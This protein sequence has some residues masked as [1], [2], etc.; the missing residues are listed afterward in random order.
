MERE[1]P[2]TGQTSANIR[3]EVARTGLPATQVAQ[4]V[5]LTY[6]QWQRRINNKVPWRMD[7]VGAIARFLRVRLDVLTGD[8]GDGSTRPSSQ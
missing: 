3:A 2:S 5:G 1:A 7:E 6:P 4:A 8:R